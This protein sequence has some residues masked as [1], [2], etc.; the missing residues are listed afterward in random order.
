[1]KQVYIYAIRNNLNGFV[2]IGRTQNTKRRWKN[3][4]FRLIR[5][6]SDHK[7]LQMAW[8]LY[9][10]DCFTFL[11]LEKCELSDGVKREQ[12]WLMKE[13]QYNIV[14]NP[15]GGTP[16]GRAS[17]LLGVPRSEETKRKI[18]EGRT[19]IGKGKKASIETRMKMRESHLRRYGH[20][21]LSA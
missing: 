3:H 17:P 16:R 6:T 4:R 19:G 8:N 1:M 13:P 20:A 9:G 11:I 18:S 21:D 2:Y 12:V 15:R 14:F 10:S 7:L 5:N